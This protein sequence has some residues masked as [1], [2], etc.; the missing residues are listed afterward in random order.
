MENTK[1]PIEIYTTD[2]LCTEIIRRI[3]EEKDDLEI[4]P[5]IHL[6]YNVLFTEMTLA[7]H[8]ERN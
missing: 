4:T 6:L 2:E 3:E 5:K 1:L 8:K 7:F